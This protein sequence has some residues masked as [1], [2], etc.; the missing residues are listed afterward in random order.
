MRVQGLSLNKK[1]LKAS[2]KSGIQECPRCGSERLES[3][4]SGLYDV[5]AHWL[6]MECEECKLQY[7]ESYTLTGIEITGHGIL[8]VSKK[9]L[10]KVI[11]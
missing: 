3:T 4:T 7:N 5:K 10:R 6:Q 9:V 11:P 1:K 8:P 2:V